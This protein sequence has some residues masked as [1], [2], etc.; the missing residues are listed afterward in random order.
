MRKPELLRVVD[1]MGRLWPQS[2]LADAER[3]DPRTLE[4][5]Y[6]MLGPLPFDAACR[7]VDQLAKE[8]REFAPPVGLVFRYAEV[9][10]IAARPRLV[11]ESDPTPEER[12]R[13]KARVAELR[14][15]ID[16]LASQKALR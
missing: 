10:A 4:L 6:E 3:A 11:V 9:I 8:G 14:Q 16:T 5:W 12:E 7:A 2:G 15:Q 1:R 13:G